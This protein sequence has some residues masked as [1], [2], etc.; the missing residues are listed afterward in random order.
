MIRRPGNGSFEFVVAARTREE[1]S[2]TEASGNPTKTKAG[3]L[4]EMSASISMA[5]P[6]SPNR[7]I[8]CVF[9]NI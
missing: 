1:A 5:R 2:F 4:L 3:R 8:E 7:L 6:E 9:A